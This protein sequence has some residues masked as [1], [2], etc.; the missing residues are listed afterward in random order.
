MFCMIY[1]H[2]YVYI[3]QE[4][5]LFLGKQFF[6]RENLTITLDKNHKTHK[7]EYKMTFPVLPI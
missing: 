2:I 4:T 1:I 3:K 7:S 6:E 5:S